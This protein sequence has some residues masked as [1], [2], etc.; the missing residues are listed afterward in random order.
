[1]YWRLTPRAFHALCVVHARRQQ[2]ET[3]T[4]RQLLQWTAGTMLEYVLTGLGAKT[5]SGEPWEPADFFPLPRRDLAPEDGG[6][7][8]L[9]ELA[10]LQLARGGDVPEHVR[11]ALSED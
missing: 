10:R 3:E 6:R 2:A 1:M 5:V 7:S 11:R 8:P 4:R 9:L